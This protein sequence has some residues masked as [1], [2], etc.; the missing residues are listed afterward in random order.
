MYRLHKFNVCVPKRGSLGMR[1][2]FSGFYSSL[3]PVLSGHIHATYMHGLGMMR[4]CIL[5]PK[6]HGSFNTRCG[7]HNSYILGQL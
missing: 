7:L 1:L 2:I 4:L 5:I 6:L 3:H